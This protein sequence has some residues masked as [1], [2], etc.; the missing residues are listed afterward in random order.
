MHKLKITF[1]Q[2]GLH[3]F[4]RLVW[5]FPLFLGHPVYI[6]K[7]KLWNTVI[8]FPQRY[9]VYIYIYNMYVSYT[10]NVNWDEI[11][12]LVIHIHIVYIYL[13]H[14]WL[15]LPPSSRIKTPDWP[16]SRNP[17]PHP[18]HSWFTSKRF[19]IENFSQFM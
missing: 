11:L 10:I 6:H 9:P 19:V 12:V 8:F 15:I 5:S 13:K 14:W 18:I 1:T 4:A 3:C 17:P 7:F 2:S 16:S